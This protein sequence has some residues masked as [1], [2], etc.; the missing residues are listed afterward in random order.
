MSQNE[1]KKHEKRKG[2][3]IFL[4][5]ST[6]SL[7]IKSVSQVKVLRG[8][9]SNPSMYVCSFQEFFYV[10]SLFFQFSQNLN[11]FCL[12]Y[13]PDAAEWKKKNKN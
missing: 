9:S 8:S 1:L 5:V 4:F 2:I 11:M 7:K 6:V 10:K 3:L 13:P 12:L